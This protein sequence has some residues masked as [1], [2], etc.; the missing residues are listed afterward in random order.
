MVTY[1]YSSMK[2]CNSIQHWFPLCLATDIQ[3][4]LCNSSKGSFQSC[5]DSLRWLISELD[6]GLKVLSIWQFNQTSK[7]LVQNA[8]LSADISQV[9]KLSIINAWFTCSRLIGNCGCSSVVI[10]TRN[11]S[12]T[13]SCV[14]TVS[15][16]SSIKSRPR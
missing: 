7:Q 12:C 16:S 1:L 15:S 8:G 11:A 6:R 2:E 10:H 13:G 9:Y 5:L 3:L 14:V 4:I